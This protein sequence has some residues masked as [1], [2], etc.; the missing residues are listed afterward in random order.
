MNAS[1][2][3]EL[4]RRAPFVRPAPGTRFRI[5]CIDG[6]GIRG[7]IPA[8]VLRH[9]ESLLEARGDSAPLAERFQLLAGTSTGGL[10]AL[11]LSGRGASGAPLLN[12]AELVELY[13]GEDGR[14][15]FRR[16][17]IRRLPLL[18]RL[19]DL[20]LPK[21]SLGPLRR[22]LER[23][24][25]EALLGDALSEVMVTAYDMTERRPTFFKRWQ[26]DAAAR[27]I[28]DAAL[29]TAAA[30]TFFPPHEL[31]GRALVDGGLFAANPTVAAI[32]EALKRTAAPAALEPND[33]LVVSL[34][35]GHHEIRFEPAA[36]RRWGAADWAL[37]G[38][39]GD[40]PLIA[41]M[42]DGQSDA[43]D[44]WAHVLLNHEPGEP[45][46]HGAAIGVGPRYY[47]FQVDLPRGLPLDDPSPG[48]IGLL[49]ECGDALIEAR[50]AELEALA[51][52]LAR[53]PGDSG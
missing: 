51:G 16:P 5:L 7:V 21:Y 47:R 25:G 42:L 19:I 45:M 43:A 3:S 52:E 29:A 39:G 35:T 34:G 27:P 30:P 24:Y 28:V 32:V 11:G 20:V 6:G 18:R 31:E 4:A 50:A 48:N 38:R 12:A 33:L 46:A 13:E 36:T 49:A 10:I 40:P 37:P 1:E 9:L 53:S 14:E 17:L 26:P 41:A 23:R 2:A 22:V 44:H 15:I 8:R